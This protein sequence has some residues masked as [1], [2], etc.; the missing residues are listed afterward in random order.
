MTPDEQAAHYRAW[1]AFCARFPLL[2]ANPRG[3]PPA[4]E[5]PAPLPLSPVAPSPVSAVPAAA[6]KRVL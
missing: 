4:R 1:D 5:A 2:P 3:S 6:R